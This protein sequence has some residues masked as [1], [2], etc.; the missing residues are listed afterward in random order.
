MLQYYLSHQFTFYT[1][2]FFMFK[3]ILL[4]INKILNLLIL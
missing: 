1:E 3:N 4:I 2:I